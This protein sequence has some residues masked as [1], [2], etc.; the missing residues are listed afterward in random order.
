MIHIEQI[1][2][3]INRAS[4]K[5]QT[6]KEYLTQLDQEIGDGDH[7]INLSRGFQEVTKKITL[8]NYQEIGSLFQD[9]SMVLISKVGGA[10]GPL[11]GTA[12]MKAASICKGKEE[13]TMD[14]FANLLEEAVNGLKLRGK[15]QVGDKTMLDVWEPIARFVR[16]QGE[17]LDWQQ[18]METSKKYM[19]NTKHLQ[20]NKGRAAYLGPRSIGHLDPGAVSS[21]F[22]FE[23]LCLTMLESGDE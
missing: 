3:W 12:F 2:R 22:L 18:L 7:G 6:Q 21:H 20:A 11:Y 5:I 16:E 10:S 19:E 15:A 1:I 8:K 17:T 23:S 13:L 14:D 4:E 9:I